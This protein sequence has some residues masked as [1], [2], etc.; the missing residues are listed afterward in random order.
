MALFS[1][2]GDGCEDCV[3]FRNI[4]CGILLDIKFMA[5]NDILRSGKNSNMARRHCVIPNVLTLLCTMS[6]YLMLLICLLMIS[7]FNRSEAQGLRFHGNEMVIA[8]RSALTIPSPD[9]SVDPEEDSRVK[10]VAD[11]WD[12]YCNSVGRNSVLLLNLPP[13]RRG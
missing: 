6:R 5:R 3:L 11:L 10:T 9:D 7:A 8:D 4:L 13:D 12:I 2:T 1:D